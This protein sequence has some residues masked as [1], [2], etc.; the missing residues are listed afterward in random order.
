MT[1]ISEYANEK[2]LDV[3]KVIAMIRSGEL[4]GRLQNGNWFVNSAAKNNA[5]DVHQKESNVLSSQLEKQ[6]PIVGILNILSVLSMLGGVMLTLIFLPNNDR[7]SSPD[8]ITYLASI[9]SFMAGLV[10][11]VLFVSLGKI[12]YF[13]HK[14]SENTKNQN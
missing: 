7:Y 10:E 4:E 13:L 12:I 14:I 5:Y 2:R 9:V 1:P 3:E 6:L 11:A 8:T